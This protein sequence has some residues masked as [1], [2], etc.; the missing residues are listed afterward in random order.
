MP[1]RGTRMIALT[2]EDVGNI[3]AELEVVLCRR[4]DI[5]R[6]ACELPPSST[7]PPERPCGPS[8]D[9]MLNGAWCSYGARMFGYRTST[10]RTASA[11]R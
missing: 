4:R 8:L 10:N 3:L 6:C 9:V 11:Q 5:E 1:E 2:G 7:P